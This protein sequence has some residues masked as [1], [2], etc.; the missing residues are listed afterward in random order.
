MNRQE[1]QLDLWKKWKKNPTDENL[2][3]LF[4]SFEPMMRMQMNKYKGAEIPP[5][6]V[7]LQL[8]TLMKDAFETYKPSQGASLATHVYNQTKRISRYI[9]DLQNIGKIP[10]HRR[11]K[12][13]QYMAAFQELEQALG[14]EP[15]ISELADRLK[16]P[17]VEVE[18]MESEL[19]RSK[20]ESMFDDTGKELMSKEQL[21]L[22]TIWQELDPTEKVVF[23]HTLGWGRQKLQA[24]EIA[25]KLN[26]SPAT[27]SRIRSNIASKIQAR[28]NMTP[29]YQPPT[30]LSPYR[31][32]IR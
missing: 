30:F 10:E 9:G 26:V 27:V 23:E 28:L 11:L 7:E 5:I 15:G 3:N 8:K 18:R 21:V 32:N 2:S 16:W 13:S 22:R 17:V 25:K 31:H 20:P 12:I 1:Q 6:A 24:Q 4:K 19:R 29:S 14:R